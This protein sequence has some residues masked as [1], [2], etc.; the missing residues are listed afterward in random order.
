MIEFVTN[1]AKSNFILSLSFDQSYILQANLN[2][3]N[4]LKQTK[5]N[6][7]YEKN[8]DDINDDDGNIKVSSND[9][10]NTD[11]DSNHDLIIVSASVEL[12]QR[13]S[14]TRGCYTSLFN[15]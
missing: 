11:N 10:R 13:G 15:M 1:L 12:V 3:K 2:Q 6:N 4:I 9:I 8:N 5:E 14:D 7:D